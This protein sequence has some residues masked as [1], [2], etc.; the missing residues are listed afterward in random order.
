MLNKFLITNLKTH[1]AKNVKQF[2]LKKLSCS[3]PGFKKLM[4]NRVL[5]RGNSFEPSYN[6]RKH[7]HSHRLIINH[8]L[9]NLSKT[10]GYLSQNK[11]K[12]CIAQSL[13]LC[14]GIKKQRLLDTN[15]ALINSKT[16][17][18][19][20]TDLIET[21]SHILLTRNQYSGSLRSAQQK[22]NH[23][24]KSYFNLKRILDYARTKT[25]KKANVGLTQRWVAPGSVIR[26]N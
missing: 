8:Q 4:F 2:K 22:L 9:Q 25:K 15:K 13:K 11:I 10:F 18:V 20:M 1:R 5:V 19:F 6:R 14:Y 7:S 21:H 3:Q 17:L 23:Q 12:F 26:Q 24:Q 16:T